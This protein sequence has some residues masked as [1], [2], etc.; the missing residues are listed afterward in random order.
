MHNVDELILADIYPA[1][2]QPI[3]GISTKNIY[4][5]LKKKK[6]AAYI[7]KNNICNK[8]MNVAKEGDL[9]I[10]LGAGDINK[11]ADEF[12]DRLNNG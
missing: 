11:I 4:D 10:V 5:R 3:Y 12:A 1:S 6:S 8:L 9:V 2:E 7:S